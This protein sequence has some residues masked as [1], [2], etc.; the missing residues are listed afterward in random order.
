MRW[1]ILVPYQEALMSEDTQDSPTAGEEVLDDA[2]LEAASGG[3]MLNST[4]IVYSSTFIPFDSS[5]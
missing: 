1:G 4:Q 2:A 3:Q 5:F